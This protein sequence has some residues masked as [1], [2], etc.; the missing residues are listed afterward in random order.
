MQGRG[1]EWGK[2]ERRKVREWKGE[3]GNEENKNEVGKREEQ[4]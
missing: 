2:G 1:W 3:S 4:V